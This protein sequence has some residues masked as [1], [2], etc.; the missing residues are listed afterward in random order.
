MDV[1]PCGFYV[2]WV[3]ESA[4]SGNDVH[5]HI[6]IPTGPFSKVSLVRV[7]T[8]NVGKRFMVTVIL[9][10]PSTNYLQENRRILQTSLTKTF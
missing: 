3:V 10:V 2:G 1:H 8:C 7:D 6:C 5:C 4:W 9:L